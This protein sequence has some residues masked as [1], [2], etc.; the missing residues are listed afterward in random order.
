MQQY[1]FQ[2]F[3]EGLSEGWTT[4]KEGSITHVPITVAT[5]HCS[6]AKPTPTNSTHS[7]MNVNAS[8]ARRFYKES[9]AKFTPHFFVY[10]RT[11]GGP[12][13]YGQICNVLQANVVEVIMGVHYLTCDGQRYYE[14]AKINVLDELDNGL[15]SQEAWGDLIDK[16]PNEEPTEHFYISAETLG[17]TWQV[18]S[19][20][21]FDVFNSGKQCTGKIP[22]Q[23][24]PGFFEPCEHGHTAMIDRGEVMLDRSDEQTVRNRLVIQP[25][26]AHGTG[27]FATYEDIELGE[28]YLVEYQGYW[29]PAEVIKIAPSGLVQVKYDE[30][31][32]TQYIGRSDVNW[33]FR[34]MKED[35]EDDDDDEDD[36]EKQESE[37][38]QDSGDSEDSEDD[39]MNDEDDEDDG[40]DE[41]IEANGFTAAE[42]AVRAAYWKEKYET[43][44]AGK[45]KCKNQTGPAGQTCHFAAQSKG[46]LKCHFNVNHAPRDESFICT[47][48]CGKV[49]IF[50]CSYLLENHCAVKGCEEAK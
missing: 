26:N 28:K 41:D 34:F 16:K 21:C 6:N 4:L 46:G 44:M 22:A 31:G 8:T 29:Y 23:G 40:D 49:R 25:V 42:S 12:L 35:S 32:A 18:F 33:R 10:V 15:L 13:R 36:E 43:P 30:D 38:K 9:N 50:G 17:A 27:D 2:S 47:G 39:I 24:R 5:A 20:Y 1:Q 45:F 11:N 7:T 48:A 37:K 3:S 14:V 19:Q